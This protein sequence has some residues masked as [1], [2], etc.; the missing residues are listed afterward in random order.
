MKQFTN[1][2]IKKWVKENINTKINIITWSIIEF[3]KYHGMLQ[4]KQKKWKWAWETSKES[5]VF[6][7]G[8]TD[9]M[10]DREA[11]YYSFSRSVRVIKLKNSEA[12]I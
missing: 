10:T 2:E 9:Y 3:V 6:D 4:S 5:C 1:E 11:E 7:C 12:E 8:I